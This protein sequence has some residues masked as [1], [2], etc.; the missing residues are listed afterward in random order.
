[1]MISDVTSKGRKNK[2]RKRVGRGIGSGLGKTAGRGHKGM[3]QHADTGVG[4]GEGGQLPLFR[5]IP[6][7]GFNNARF[8]IVY[9]VVNLA[10]LQEIFKDGAHVTPA[11][12][13]EAGL[14]RD[15]AAPVKI[16]GDGDLS[17]K[18]RIE[19]HR[20]SATASRKISDVGGEAKVIGA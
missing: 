8:R 6:K 3:G 18:F 19:A 1:M 14:I 4:L 9:Q 17:K 10:D 12:L 13:E 2:T 20:F 5:R 15:A 7:R 16:L 11:A